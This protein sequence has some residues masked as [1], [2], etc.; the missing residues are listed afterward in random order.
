MSTRH[1]EQSRP[2]RGTRVSRREILLSLGA[3]AAAPSRA[4]A[5]FQTSARPLT[6][7][8]LNHVHLIV[9][10]LQ[11]SLEFYQR[12]FGMPL[13]GMQG[14]EADWKKPVVPML[15]IGTG[16]QFISF[17][18]G[19]GQ[20]Q[21]RDRIDHFG[22]G[23]AGF[24]AE[25]VVKALAE[26][27]VQGSV[28][29]RADSTPPVAELKFRDPD[30][31]TV[32]IQDESYCGGSGV[33][34]N[35]CNHQ[36]ALKAS[37]PAPIMVRTLNHLTI[38][39]TDVE[40]AVAFYQRVFGMP[41]QANQGTEADWNKKVIP[42]LGIGGGPQFLAFSRGPSGRLD[43]FCLGMDRFDSARVVKVLAEHGIKANVRLR[44]DSQ[45]PSE[46]L[47]FA[48]PD[49]IRVQIQDVSYCGGTGVLGNNCASP[50]R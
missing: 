31:I 13:A 37:G 46:E 8:T 20:A 21:G 5:G 14:A 44:A 50:G 34:G 24:N 23:M 30:D 9:S 11:R 38:T 27:G 12:L 15:A 2:A 49:G 7:R 43:H 10:N 41:M 16:P 29:M 3:V 19:P 6:M 17:S 48:D 28:R 40:R 26:H 47:M 42:A 4:L 1:D 35:R 18:E 25:R 22:F 36:A 33:L 39:V 45:P 32:Q